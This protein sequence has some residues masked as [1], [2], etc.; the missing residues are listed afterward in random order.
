MVIYKGHT[1][2]VLHIVIYKKYIYLFNF[3]FWHTRL[4]P[5]IKFNKNTTSLLAGDENW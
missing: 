5:Q 3:L 2:I 1:Y 4:F